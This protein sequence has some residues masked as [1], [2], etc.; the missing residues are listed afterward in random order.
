MGK[1][2]V[3]V[4]HTEV[5]VEEG[6]TILKAAQIAGIYIPT[7]CYHPDL[8]S[9]EKVKPVALVY[10]GSQPVKGSGGKYE[11]CGLCV[12]EVEGMEGFPTA[13]TTPARQGMIVHTNTER[14]QELRRDN[15]ELILAKHPHACLLCAEREGCSREPCSLKVNPLE[16][17][18]PLFGHCE[19][20][21]VA[22]YIGIKKET[23]RYI[24]GGLPIVKDEPFFDRDYNL[25]IGCTRCVRVCHEVRG[26]GA[27]GVVCLDGE[28]VIGAKG[29]SFRESACRFCGACVEVC[30]TGALVDREVIV[31]ERERALVPC[32]YAC[33]AGINIAR[34][35]RLV[36]ERRFAEAVAVIR[37]KV[38]FPSILGR[39]CT[40]PCEGKC[41]RGELNEPIAICALKRFAAEHD[42]GSW[43]TSVKAAP[44]TGKRVA[45]VGSGPAG[46]TA[47]YYL[48]K[49][50]HSITVFEALPEPGG[51]MRVGIPEY[52]L[53]KN[54]LDAE[55]EE[56]RQ[57]G[58]DIRTNTRVES[59]DNLFEQGFNGVFLALGAC[60][61]MKMG[62][63]GEDSP[64]V[65]E[66]IC[67]LRDVNLGEEV[68]LQGKAA[69]IG[70]GNAAID[71]A[72]A[73][74][75]LGASEVTI[76][77]RRSRAEMPA[78]PDEIEAAIDEGVKLI[79][80]AV[81][82]KITREN[83]ELRV[84][85]LRMEL[86]EPD[87][88]RRPRPIPIKGSEF[89]MN[90]DNVIVAIG[91]MPEIPGQFALRIG[92][93]NTLQVDPDTLLTSK[94]GVFAGG[95]VVSGPASVIEAIAA[96]RQAA[97]SIDRYLGGSGTIDEELIQMEEPSPWLG[98]GDGFADRARVQMPCL[99]AEERLTGFAETNLGLGEEIA[100]EEAK[101]CLQCNLRLHISPVPFPPEKWLE[102]NPNNVNAVP[103]VEGV[104]QLVSDQKAIIYIAGTMNLLQELKEHLGE[105]EGPISKARYF[106]YEENP[107]YT[108]RESELIQQF[109]QEH[110]TM[111]EGNREML[112]IF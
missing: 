69:V 3:A 33:P 68:R 52:R 41:R 73:A 104:Y 51:M 47:A 21:K 35:I 54:V 72:R 108:A 49:Q 10:R 22:Q 15:L 1:I 91:Q 2:T 85:C 97:M 12:V 87:A 64:G 89:T 20:Q 53:P 40:H 11:G 31:A 24:F 43:K 36:A 65:L 34:Y 83:G 55:I 66:G 46:L 18:C 70:G 17:C 59:L 27:I 99:P 78:M 84:E 88:S 106:G 60:Q 80:L 81:P 79:F 96:G 28:I 77:Y 102:F 57:V 29:P 109:I 9:F 112:D 107:M 50:G 19:L 111:P 103:E 30:P 98:P 110:G 26:V 56:I 58:V 100:I 23:P 62:V 86:G 82:N 67:L 13:C 8:P 63:D 95:D 39:V 37:E 92:D 90:F 75:R 16:R 42:T 5:E 61:G 105:T 25:C 101:R 32:I 48:A 44:P 6:S 76:I 71:S 45:I 94:E 14:V 38:P 4:D 7:L 74:L 93:G